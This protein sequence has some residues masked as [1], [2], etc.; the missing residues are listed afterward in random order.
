MAPEVL[1]GNYNE[2]CDIWSLG[3]VLYM[4]LSGKLPFDAHSEEILKK[5]ILRAE[6]STHGKAFE[7]VSEDAKDLIQN[8]LKGDPAK[9]YSAQQCLDHPWITNVL[10]NMQNEKTIDLKV[11]ERIANFKGMSALKNA[12]WASVIS[13]FSSYDETV[14]IVKTWTTLDKKGLGVLS[15]EDLKSGNFGCDVSSETGSKGFEAADMA[16][17]PA[18]LDLIFTALTF[19]KSGTIL[20]TGNFA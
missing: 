11:M 18:E 6:V 2:K 4:L 15:K 12:F 17:K 16:M 14:K 13:Y 7:K 10:K 5:K 20:Y 8:M 1:E 19:N 3:V 9:R